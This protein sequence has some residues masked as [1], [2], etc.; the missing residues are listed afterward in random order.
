MS[1]PNE[2]RPFDPRLTQAAFKDRGGGQLGLMAE[3][4]VT[5]TLAQIGD[6]LGKLR[7]R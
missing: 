4:H 5:V 2:I 1:I 3:G 6:L 7:K